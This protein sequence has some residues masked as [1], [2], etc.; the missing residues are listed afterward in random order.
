VFAPNGTANGLLSNFTFG[1]PWFDGFANLKNVTY[2]MHFALARD[3]GK[4]YTNAV[5][6]TQRCIDSMGP[7]KLHAVAIG[8]EPDLFATQDQRPTS[9]GPAE[10]VDEAKTYMSLLGSNVSGIPS[11]R[12]FQIF[13]RSSED[14]RPRWTM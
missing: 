9:Y 11:G 7:E 13:D 14:N 8:N 2:T 6:F 4:N 1:R 3:H 10:Y 12:A 5:Q